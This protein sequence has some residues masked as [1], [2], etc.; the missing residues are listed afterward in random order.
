MRYVQVSESEEK[1]MQIREYKGQLKQ[2]AGMAILLEK[3]KTS[4]EDYERVE[5]YLTDIDYYIDNYLT[6]IEY[7]TF[8]AHEDGKYVGFI[9]GKHWLNDTYNLV[10][11]YVHPDYR[12]SGI[13]FKLKEKLTEHAKERGYKRI[14]SCV[15]T[16][17]FVSNRL[18]EKAGWT[19]E[20]DKVWKDIY[21][22]WTKELQ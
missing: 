5:V 2:I 14:V 7:N 9:V 4:A 17:H 22:W 6:S 21:V 13:A 1:L 15:R 12:K 18:N 3:L 19:K 20:S 8:M 11:L 16:D 10:M